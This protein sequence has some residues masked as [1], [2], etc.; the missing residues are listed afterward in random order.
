[1]LD[2]LSNEGPP[3]VTLTAKGRRYTAVE[4]QAAFTAKLDAKKP[5]TSGGTLR[6]ADDAS[7][8]AIAEHM[9]AAEP[10]LWQHGAW[11][12]AF[13]ALTG[14]R[15]FPSQSEADHYLAREI[16][17]CSIA[18]GT[19]GDALETLVEAVFDESALAQRDKWKDRK[20]YR[21]STIK[22]AC[23]GL[24]FQTSLQGASASVIPDWTLK[25]DVRA[26]R[27][28]RDLYQGQLYFVRSVGKWMLWS[29]ATRRWCWCDLG[30][31]VELVTQIVVQM[32]HHALGAAKTIEPEAG[33][34]LIAETAALQTGYR[35]K[36]VLD[37]LKSMEGLSIK[38]DQL[39]S[40]PRLLGVENGI[41]D[42]ESGTLHP[43][44]P[45]FLITNHIGVE[46]DPAALAPRWESFLAEVFCNDCETIDAVH[47]LVGMTITGDVE[48]EKMIFCI[49]NGANGKS[50]F[51]NTLYRLI[52][53]YA[54]TA[55]PSLLAARRADDHG[56]RPEIAMLAGN[57]LV[58]INEPEAGMTLDETVVKQLAGSEPISARHLYQGYFTFDPQFTV[59]VRTNHRPIVRGTDNGIWRR[60]VILPFNRTFALE[61]QDLGLE[62]KLRAERAGILAWMVR[63][64]QL[65]LKN[66][67]HLSKAMRAEVAQY[68]NDS[69]I[70]GEF[71]DDSVDVGANYEIE[72]SLLFTQFGLWCANNG[73][74]CPTK[75][76]FTT[77]LSE[78]GYGH[79][80]SGANR[81]YVGLRPRAR[82][83]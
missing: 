18:T 28:A 60:I 16:A 13:D 62:V 34:R 75:R 64:S 39:D 30:E 79:R 80:K 31:E 7:V 36:A 82:T 3:E 10:A 4:L 24:T 41:V 83:W 74:R 55:P 58:S 42:L 66:G 29:S 77:Q 78:R 50:L 15:R 23:L 81:F 61:E 33:K 2:N 26:A 38:P 17:K 72:Q 65:Y 46:F 45:E 21:G 56:A 48:P 22:R 9:Q 35:I 6:E 49:G 12:T 43:N 40:H 76:S 54:V 20:D 71:L 11:E 63:G 67:I 8:I 59:W 5:L 47:A 27:F 73:F 51:S 44:R 70:L 53:Q 69:D 14:A 57:R 32:Y 37:L 25:N 1:M 68:R 52:D 19:V